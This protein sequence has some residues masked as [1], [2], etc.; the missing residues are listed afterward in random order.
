MRKTGVAILP[1]HDGSVPPKLIVHMIK[2]SREIIELIVK[3]YGPDEFLRRISD[4]FWFQAF[5]C[6]LGFDWHSSG[7]TTVVT[8]VLRNA[9]S[10]DHGL[11]VLGGKGAL[12]KNVPNELE[13]VATLYNMSENKLRE[14]EYASRMTAKVDNTAIQ[15]GYQLYHH[16]FFVSKN[17]MWAV[18]QQGMDSYTKTARRYHWIS[19]GLNSFIDEPH[20]GIIGDTKKEIVLNMTAK[21]S[22]EARQIS[23]DLVKEGPRRIINDLKSIVKGPMDEWL[24]M[25]TKRDI[26]IDVLYLPK[27]INWDAV[28]RAYEIQPRNYEELLSI[29]G[30][31][32]AVVRALALV[33]ELVYG[34]PASWKD[35]VKYTFA[36]GGKDG[37][38]YPV[39]FVTYEKTI[40]TLEEAIKQSKLGNEEKI[41]A[42]KRLSHFSLKFEK[43]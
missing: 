26:R 27:R 6:V 41:S 37:V 28:R 5:G 4:P 7:L 32:P 20:K 13:I 2:L 19:E 8:G 25:K 24:D 15:D 42:L 31:G 29:R 18:V 1:L 9:V 21:Q 3:E 35:P 33:S 43:S 17:G 40:N 22:S 39:D 14:F 11:L 23:V 30:I 12:S 34:K 36:H 16:A 38:P 10:P